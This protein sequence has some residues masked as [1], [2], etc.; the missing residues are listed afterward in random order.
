MTNNADVKNPEK[1]HTGCFN[2]PKNDVILLTFQRFGVNGRFS[3]PGRCGFA[4]LIFL[5]KIV[6]V[7][8]IFRGKSRRDLMK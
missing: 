1:W 4:K 6:F 5:S 2:H 7:N 3:K 8:F